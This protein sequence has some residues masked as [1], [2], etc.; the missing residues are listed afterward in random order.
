MDAGISG[1]E[2]IPETTSASPVKRGARSRGVPKSAGASRKKMPKTVKKDEEEIAEE[3]KKA[4]ERK[5]RQA[6]FESGDLLRDD[7][8]PFVDEACLGVD[9]PLEDAKAARAEE[10]ARDFNILV[11]REAVERRMK[12]QEGG[13]VVREGFEGDWKDVPSLLS[14]L[15][16]KGAKPVVLEGLL[17]FSMRVMARTVRYARRRSRVRVDVDNALSVIIGGPPEMRMTAVDPIPKGQT[18]AYYPMVVRTVGADDP[19]RHL[20]DVYRGAG[21]AFDLRLVVDGNPAVADTIAEVLAEKMVEHGVVDEVNAEEIKSLFCAHRANGGRREDCNAEL[22]WE[23][24]RHLALEL[25]AL[26][27]ISSE[28]EIVCYYGDD[29]TEVSVWGWVKRE[30]LLVESLQLGRIGRLLV[31]SLFSE[32]KGVIFME[33]RMMCDW[34]PLEEVVQRTYA[35]DCVVVTRRAGMGGLF[36]V[37]APRDLRGLRVTASNE[38]WGALEA[39]YQTQVPFH[40]VFNNNT[41]VVGL[42]EVSLHDGAG[43]E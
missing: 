1:G 25:R 12:D 24:D 13:L 34:E 9:G 38:E 32:S 26:R 7:L 3:R 36:A 41:K 22:A 23:T 11:G 27:P 33:E 10:M 19:S 8:L 35:D 28:E 42:L 18:I 20:S 2:E 31:S 21:Q 16:R 14:A 30:A 17:T 5:E 43:G 15:T 6:R 37:I 39:T 29:F 40:Y 4:R